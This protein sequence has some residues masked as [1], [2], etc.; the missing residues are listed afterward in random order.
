[1][2]NQEEFVPVLEEKEL[3]EGKMK[4]ISVEGTPILLIK[5]QGKIFAID[6]RCPHQACS[7]SNG[8]LDG[9]V[10][11]CPCHDWRFNLETGEYEDDPSL[12]LATFEWKVEAGKIYVK[13]NEDTDD[14]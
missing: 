7:L 1:M 2:E 13:I 12:K 6:N 8:T 4:R 9:L 11:I 10:I 5:Q 3:Q 14:S